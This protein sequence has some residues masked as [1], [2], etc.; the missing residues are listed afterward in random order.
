MLAG[1]SRVDVDKRLEDAMNALAKFRETDP[2]AA[3]RLTA[4]DGSVRAGASLDMLPGGDFAAPYWVDTER[5]RLTWETG[6]EHEVWTVGSRTHFVRLEPSR[7]FGGS[8]G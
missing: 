5:R 4:V 8:D 3:F 1:V 7:E 6:P 2:G